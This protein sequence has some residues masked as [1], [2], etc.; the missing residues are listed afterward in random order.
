M[1]NTQLKLE[2]IEL[3]LLK[4]KYNQDTKTLCHMMYGLDI[5]LAQFLDGIVLARLV[6]ELLATVRTVPRSCG[7]CRS[8]ITIRNN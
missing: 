3:I 5:Q 1:E 6:Q 2:S 8:P 4:L 7:T